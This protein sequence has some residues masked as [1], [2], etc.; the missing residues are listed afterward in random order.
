MISTADRA[1]PGLNPLDVVVEQ[2]QHRFDV[3]GGERFVTLLDDLNIP[4]RRSDIRQLPSLRIRCFD[5]DGLGRS[6][7]SRQVRLADQS[8]HSPPSQMVWLLAAG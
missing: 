3:T 1:L 4:L 6:G 5:R 7:E 2:A 8:D